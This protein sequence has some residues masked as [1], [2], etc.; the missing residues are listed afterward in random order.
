M[1]RSLRVFLLA[2]GLRPKMCQFGSIW[3]GL[4]RKALKA[5]EHGRP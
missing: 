2:R 5:T 3:G 1:R 4:I